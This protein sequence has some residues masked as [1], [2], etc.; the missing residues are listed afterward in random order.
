MHRIS[1]GQWLA[2]PVGMQVATI[3]EKRKIRTRVV[4]PDTNAGLKAVPYRKGAGLSREADKQG[5]GVHEKGLGAVSGV[6]TAETK[7]R[8]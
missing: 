7:A 3:L 6:G 5:T 2:C 4:L 8:E 1:D